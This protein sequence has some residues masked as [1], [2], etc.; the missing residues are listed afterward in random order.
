[1]F[2][3][4]KDYNINIETGCWE[5]N[6]AMSGTGYGQKWYSGKAWN[7]HRLSWTIYNGAIPEGLYVCHSCDNRKC[8]NPGHLWVGTQG[9]N[10]RDMYAKGRGDRIRRPDYQTSVDTI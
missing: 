8:M 7:V 1:M 6:R 9:D 2:I 4:G 5:W 10:L 3:E